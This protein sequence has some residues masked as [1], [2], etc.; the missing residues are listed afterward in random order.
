MTDGGS[1]LWLQTL[2]EGRK[3]HKVS[4]LMR[5][6]IDENKPEIISRWKLNKTILF[7][8]MRNNLVDINLDLRPYFHFHGRF[9][10]IQWHITAYQRSC[11]PDTV[12]VWNSCSINNN[13]SITRSILDCNLQWTDQDILT[14]RPLTY[15][16]HSSRE[17][18]FNCTS[19]QPAVPVLQ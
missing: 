14:P 18:S 7:Y 4:L 6:L 12:V 2:Q 15:F 13:C 11:I 1:S 5:I 17:P 10:Q 3:S 19:A 9:M 16:L 8:K